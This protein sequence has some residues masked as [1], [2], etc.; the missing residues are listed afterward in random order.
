MNVF[1]HAAEPVAR[2]AV[3]ILLNTLWEDA[4]VFAAMA[5]LLRSWRNLNAATRYFAWCIALVAAVAVPALTMHATAGA[6][7]YAP[8]AAHFAARPARTAIGTMPRDGVTEQRP[9]H[10]HA[11]VSEPRVAPLRITVPDGAAL[12]VIAC[13]AL[14]AFFFMLR[15]VV[16]LARLEGLKRNALPLPM[17]YRNALERWNAGWSPSRAVRICVSDETEVPVAV[18]LFD[19][20][21][22]IPRSLLASLS[23][24]EVSQIYLHERAH[25]RRADDWTNLVQRS[26]TALLW[27]SPGIYAIARAL[28][29]ERE[30]ACDDDVVAQTGA[31]RPYA[32]CLTHMAEITAW[33][34]RPL[35]APGA[36]VTRRGISERIERL[37]SAGRSAARGLA[38]APTAVALAIVGAFALAA[39]A[40][41]V[42]LASPAA[43]APSRVRVLH[44]VHRAVVPPR[45]VHVRAVNVDVP[46]VNVRIPA[47]HFDMPA[48]NFT[49]PAMS[50]NIP[51]MH[52]DVPNEE[53]MME[54]RFRS[55]SCRSACDFSNVD[56]AGANLSG[57]SYSASDFSNADLRRVNFANARFAAVD[58]TDADLR[59]ADFNGARF[60]Y[61]DF[62]DAHLDGATFSG[63]VIDVCDFTGA[64]LTG[65]DLSRAHLDGLCEESLANR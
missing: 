3:A 25:L 26:V 30:A 17:E 31:V 45:H 8:T 55:A 29:V 60:S 50:V 38:I 37:L 63:A 41:G 52:I 18:G 13:W 24:G 6:S 9:S 56:W 57:R 1:V 61:V 12:A 32:R 11:T 53:Q 34:H 59:H 23:P 43:P 58:F 14:A 44:P 51:A 42:T 2:T 4:V 49:M 19:A 40:V 46:A 16:A 48:V 54:R 36:F 21:I 7:A 28:D 62:T 39:P 65:V 64:D 35:P 5:L 20:M 27:F 47:M 33:P 22:L 10:E 15:L